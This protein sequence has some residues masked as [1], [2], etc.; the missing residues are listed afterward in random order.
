[1]EKGAIKR[2]TCCL[3]LGIFLLGIYRATESTSSQL[4]AS[5]VGLDWESSPSRDRSPR[6]S[7]VVESI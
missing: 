4:A 6:G 7:T 1:M 5:A 2:M 3:S